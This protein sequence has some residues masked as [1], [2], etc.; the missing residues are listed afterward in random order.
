MSVDYPALSEN[1]IA[2][3]IDAAEE[4]CDPLDELV[5]KTASDP[6]APFAPETLK[7]IAV[8]KKGDRPAFEALRAQLQKAAAG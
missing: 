2:A 8:L 3:I 7:R 4:I 1:L 5:E 6:G